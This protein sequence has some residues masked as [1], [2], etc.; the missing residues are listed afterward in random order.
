MERWAGAYQMEQTRANKLEQEVEQLLEKCRELE[1]MNTY[2]KA[3]N[4]V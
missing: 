2:L 3:S 4:Q 1:K